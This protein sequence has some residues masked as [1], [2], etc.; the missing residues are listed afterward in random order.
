MERA[1]AIKGDKHSSTHVTM[2]I[3]FLHTRGPHRT[4]RTHGNT[5]VSRPNTKLDHFLVEQKYIRKKHCVL[6]IH[7]ES[8]RDA[9]TRGWEEYTDHKPVE[10]TVRLVPPAFYKPSRTPMRRIAVH[11]GRGC[12]DE[13]AA[14][15]QQCTQTLDTQLQE[16]NSTGLHCASSQPRQPRKS[17]DTWNAHHLG[18][19]SQAA[20]R[21]SIK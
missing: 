15:R 3:G 2:N 14:L 19:G 8:V 17:L 13:A 12:S 4:T 9:Q 18:N 1:N 7:S 10:M 5:L 21:K 20:R 16:R 11:R 6:T